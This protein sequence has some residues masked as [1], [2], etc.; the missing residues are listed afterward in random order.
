MGVNTMSKPNPWCLRAVDFT[1]EE[2]AADENDGRTLEGYA[3]VFNTPTE[4]NS[5]EGK[6][7]EEIARGA[8]SKTL[9][10]RMPVLQF[11]HGHDARTGTVPIGKFED[12][13]EDKKGLKVTARLFDNPVVEPIRQAIE[14]GAISGMSFRFQV[15]RDQWRDKAG[16]TLK[17]NEIGELLYNPGD[18]GPLKRT[19]REVKLMEAG[20]VVFPAYAETSVG[21]RSMSDED[22]AALAEEYART[23][24]FDVESTAIIPNGSDPVT[25]PT[26]EGK[27]EARADESV[28]TEDGPEG[29]SRAKEPS[30]VKSE[31]DA[32]RSEGTSPEITGYCPDV[33]KRKLFLM[34]LHK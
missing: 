7:S 9:A 18:R 6:F 28:G 20:P 31:G 15:V 23:S 12:I 19:I 24:S 30:E 34:N 33:R 1:V 11:D 16:K 13:R 22:R 8:F 14:G 27:P 26:E 5:W 29:E 17:P 3:A 2:R 4:I 10:E 32:A 21:V 25:E